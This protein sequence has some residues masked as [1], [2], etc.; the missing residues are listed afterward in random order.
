[1][2]VVAGPWGTAPAVSGTNRA[3]ARISTASV[4]SLLPLIRGEG[5]AGRAQGAPSEVPPGL[6]VVVTVRP[7]G[8]WTLAT[9]F[10]AQIAPELVRVIGVRTLGDLA[11]TLSSA[12]KPAQIAAINE[13]ALRVEAIAPGAWNALMFDVER[14][15][16][17][18]ADADLLR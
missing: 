7:V 8:G 17:D 10:E 14:L 18:S 5:E 15:F 6:G 13:L 9:W 4:L 2:T 1:V 11:L 16:A 3:A 12:V